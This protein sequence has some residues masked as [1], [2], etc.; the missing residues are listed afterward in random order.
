MT[1]VKFANPQKSNAVKPWVNDVFDSF[2]ND[3]FISDRMVS[4]VPAV[5]VSESNGH[6]H[7]ELAAPGLKKDDFKISVDKNTLSI[8]VEKSA[9]AASEDKKYNRREFSYFSFVRSFTLPE[10]VDYAGIEARYNDGILTIELAKKEEAR[11][12]T[13][14]IQVK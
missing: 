5:N 7:I 4:R 11:I 2:F 8:S 13:R 14:E 9:E 12:Q 1:L 6:Y 10:T 3:S